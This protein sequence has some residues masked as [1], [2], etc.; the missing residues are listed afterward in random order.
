MNLEF[1]SQSESKKEY[2]VGCLGGDVRIYFQH[3]GSVDEAKQKWIERCKRINF[4]NIFVLFT[5]RDGCT[6]QN[7]GE[8]DSLPYENKIVFTNRSYPEINSA[9]HI[10]GFEDQDTVGNCFGYLNRFSGVRYYDQ[11]PYVSWFNGEW[12]NRNI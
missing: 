6:Y 10:R 1:L 9:F 7:L 4:D 11:F 12:K 5:D 3:Y 2:P 8:F